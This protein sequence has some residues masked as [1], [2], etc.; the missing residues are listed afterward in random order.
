MV[1]APARKGVQLTKFWMEEKKSKNF[2][3]GRETRWKMITLVLY[4]KRKFIF[5]LRDFKIS[6]DILS[7]IVA[8]T[9]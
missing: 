5:S 9:N 2:L 3:H 4:S 7:F 8:L 1:R 6:V